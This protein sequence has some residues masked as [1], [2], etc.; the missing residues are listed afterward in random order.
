MSKSAKLSTLATTFFLFIIFSKVQLPMWWLINKRYVQLSSSG[1]G[2]RILV[3]YTCMTRGF[4]N[5]PLSRFA[6]S[7]K[8]IVH[9]IL[10]SSKIFVGNKISKL[11]EF[12]KITP[13][14][15]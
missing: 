5:I 9:P 8:K 1:G 3:L 4:Q 13:K 10:P 15:P 14:H 7:R 2:T 11:E 6:L 12:K